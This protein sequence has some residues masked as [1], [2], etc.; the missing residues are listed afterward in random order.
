MP[1]NQPYTANHKPWDHFGNLVPQVEYSESERPHGEFLPAP[2]LPLDVAGG[3]QDKYVEEYFSIMP[4]KIVAMARDGKLVPAGLLRKFKAA[5]NGDVVLKYTTLDKEQKV[6]S[7]QSGDYVSDTDINANAGAGW[8]KSDIK[9]ALVARGYLL[10]S[11]NLEYFISSPMAVAPYP[12]YNAMSYDDPNNPATLKKHNFN[13]QHRVAILCDYVLELPWVP[14]QVASAQNL[15][16]IGEAVDY[17]A[18]QTKTYYIQFTSTQYLPIAPSTLRTKW[19]FTND[20]VP[21]FKNL[22]NRLRDLKATGDYFID[23]DL[24][25][26]YF[27]HGG[28]L[29][30]A[31]GAAYPVNVQFY[32][33]NS[34]SDNLITG[35]YACVVGPIQE[36][37]YLIPTV[38]SNWQPV[39]KAHGNF[40]LSASLTGG[41]YDA[42]KEATLNTLLGELEKNAEEQALIIGQVLQVEKHPK[43][44][45]QDVRTFGQNLSNDLFLDKMPGSATQ[46]LPDK[47]TYAG[48]ANKVARINIIRK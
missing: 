7:L 26:L 20:T 10:S 23:D 32:H 36:G 17:T 41:T 16:T 46:G 47:L 12:Y 44:L 31:T 42:G 27:F 39:Q 11:E 19:T 25:R 30:A 14:E 1:T 29:A 6:V 15:D 9:T 2:W 3:V 21:L 24:D 4:G 34:T 13:L 33:Y 48:G 38:K 43:G 18:T 45:L 28:N 5:A 40:K 22:K 35:K 8:F 37:D